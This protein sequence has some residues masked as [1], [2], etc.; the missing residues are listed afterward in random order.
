MLKIVIDH[1]QQRNDKTILALELLDTIG[2]E[3]L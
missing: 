3:Y 1:I 2:T